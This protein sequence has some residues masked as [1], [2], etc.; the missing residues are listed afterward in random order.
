MSEQKLSEYVI[1]QALV[2]AKEQLEVMLPMMLLEY[3][4]L[5]SDE[6]NLQ[7]LAARNLTTMGIRLGLMRVHDIFSAAN[8]AGDPTRI[9]EMLHEIG[10]VKPSARNPRR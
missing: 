7:A 2:A 3:A 5:D 1:G 9:D 6:E 4:G 10:M 8:E